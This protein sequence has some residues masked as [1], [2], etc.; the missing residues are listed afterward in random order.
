[1]FTIILD[2]SRFVDAGFFNAEIKAMV[3]YAKASPP[4]NPD[5]PVLVAGEPEKLST[6]A[7]SSGIPLAAAT[8]QAMCSA[9]G[10]VGVTDAEMD[11]L[12]NSA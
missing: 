12:I 9:A 5:K 10:E 11:S 2:P 6:S 8:W 4:Q 3:D 1:M 7:R